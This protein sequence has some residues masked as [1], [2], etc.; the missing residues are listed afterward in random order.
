MVLV[1]IC[2]KILQLFF[3][4]LLDDSYRSPGCVYLNF[5]FIVVWNPLGIHN[6]LGIDGQIIQPVIEDDLFGV[7]KAI[8]SKIYVFM[9]HYLTFEID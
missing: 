7:I 1:Y 3:H 4:V 5:D 9:D 6:T 8:L 2:Y